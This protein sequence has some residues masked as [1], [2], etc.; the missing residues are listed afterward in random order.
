MG[1]IGA[2][3]EKTGQF[4]L[5]SHLHGK[6]LDVKCKNVAA[7]TPVIMYR[8]TQNPNQLWYL[9]ED[10]IIYSKLNG[11][12][13]I[14]IDGCM[15]MAPYQPES[16]QRWAL[17][18]SESG[19]KIINLDA[20]DHCVDIFCSNTVDGAKVVQYNYRAAPNQQWAVYKV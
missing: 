4:Y 19:H 1:S 13:L 16:K 14:Y 2:F 3:L 15:C 11:M 9:D 6:V 7:G 20:P 10:N 18:K 5:R 12:A 8:R 17:A